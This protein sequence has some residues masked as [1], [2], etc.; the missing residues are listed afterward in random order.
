MDRVVRY[1]L[2][3]QRISD[4]RRVSARTGTSARSR[5][6]QAPASDTSTLLAI[7]EGRWEEAWGQG[8]TA[9]TRAGDPAAGGEDPPSETPRGLC[10]DL[11]RDNELVVDAGSSSRSLGEAPDVARNS[12]GG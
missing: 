8:R 9:Q 1:R 10:L 4:W 7:G 12:P 3:G 11:G 2:I 5:G 6:N